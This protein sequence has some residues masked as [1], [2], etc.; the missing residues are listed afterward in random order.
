MKIYILVLAE[1]LAGKKICKM[2]DFMSSCAYKLHLLSSVKVWSIAM[3]VSFCLSVFLSV[4]C[5]D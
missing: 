5:Y 2:A 1:R 4:R 3:S